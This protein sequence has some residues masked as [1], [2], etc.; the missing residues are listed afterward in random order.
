MGLL[1]DY[2]GN[3]SDNYFTEPEVVGFCDQCSDVL[4]AGAGG[5]MYDGNLYCCEKCVLEAL[6]A[7]NVDGD[8]RV[9]CDNC[10]CIIEADEERYSVG[11]ENY[12]IRDCVL[13]FYDVQRYEFIEE[14]II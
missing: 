4:V 10:D 6:G 12:C 9:A 13:E 11:N 1:P 2:F 7:M 14:A 5:I 8:Y 3:I